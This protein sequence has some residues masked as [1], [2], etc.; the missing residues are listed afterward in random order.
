[1]WHKKCGGDIVVDVSNCF[2]ITADVRSSSMDIQLQVVR[3]HLYQHSRTLES[4]GYQCEGCGR[5]VELTEIYST[6]RHCGD[7]INLD[8][9]LIPLESNGLYCQSCFSNYYSEEEHITMLE[10]LQRAEISVT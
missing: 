9:A 4:P 10:L 1:M 8:V 6:C 2:T 5:K 7:T 3:L